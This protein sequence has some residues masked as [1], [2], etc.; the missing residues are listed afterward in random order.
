M[1]ATE[2][3]TR[4]IRQAATGYRAGGR[5][6]YYFARA[7]L[8]HDPFYTLLLTEP[9]IPAGAHVIDLGC[10]QAL[11]GSWL[12]AAQHC[13]R[14]GL[15]DIT[16]PAPAAIA[17]YRGIDRNESEIRRARQALGDS[18]DLLVADL[19]A[20]QLDGATVIVLLD[21]LH[22]L[23]FATQRRLLSQVRAAL[24]AD[25]LLLV[26]VGDSAAGV[27]AR[28]SGWVDS[29]VLRLHG[30]GSSRLHRRPL[31]QWLLLL[32]E[33]GF[34]V[35]QIARQQSLTYANALLRATPDRALAPERDT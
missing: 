9:L 5:R 7:K 27:R 10:A 12:A 4:L 6:G 19:G 31:A 25:G 20:A 26:R 22:Y 11:L 23:D 8:R 15:W 28:V 21:V 30:Y 16:C 24:P 1:S 17:S 35:Q 33:Q 3:R 14:L 34:A 2:L 18:A 32:G 29:L 13:Y